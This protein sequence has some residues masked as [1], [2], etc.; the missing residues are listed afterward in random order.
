MYRVRP[1]VYPTS[2]DVYYDDGSWYTISRDEVEDCDSYEEFEST[3]IGI[4]EEQ[5]GYKWEELE[6][7]EQARIYAKIG[8]W[9]NYFPRI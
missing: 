3:I 7:H 5:T 6:E 8:I 2:M 1:E 9:S 4:I